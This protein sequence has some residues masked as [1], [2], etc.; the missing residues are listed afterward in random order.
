[1]ES[2]AVVSQV[3]V[4]APK[5][6]GFRWFHFVVSVA[7]GI[8]AALTTW[9][10]V[11]VPSMQETGPKAMDEISRRAASTNLNETLRLLT[12]D[13]MADFEGR[14]NKERATIVARGFGM[15]SG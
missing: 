15:A 14:Q 6:G 9:Y 12:T 2:D 3:G 8:L 5:R 4:S 1:M 11:V 10:V 13:G 7:A